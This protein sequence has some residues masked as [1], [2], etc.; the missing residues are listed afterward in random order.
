MTLGSGKLE[1]LNWSKLA[2]IAGFDPTYLHLGK[3]S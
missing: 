2:R 1:I 3:G